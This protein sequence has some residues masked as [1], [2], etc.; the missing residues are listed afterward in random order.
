MALDERRKH[1]RLEPHGSAFVVFRPEFN[2]I[3][4][5]TD[6][7]GGGVGCNYLCPVDNE[8]LTPE[9]FQ[10]I[11]IIISNNGFHLSNIPC[12][13]VY[14]V[15]ANNGKSTYLHNLVNRSCGLQF[16]PLIE[17][18]EKQI[19]YFLEKHTIGNA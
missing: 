1:E 4:P 2:K 19:H 10:I 15:R 7:S 16:D 12:N 9:R 13:L 6:I 18:Q 8:D 14:D 5:I 3:A 17:H 11:D